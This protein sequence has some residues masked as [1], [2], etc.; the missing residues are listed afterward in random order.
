MTILLVDDEILICN[1]ISMLIDQLDRNNLTTVSMSNAEDALAY[2]ETH[3]V[4][5]ILTDITMP[6][7]SGLDLIEELS[8]THPNIKTA[9][10]SAYDDY[11]Y[12]REAFKLGALD[13]ILKSEIKTEDLESL[14]NKLYLFSE[15][16]SNTALRN[17]LSK[18][19]LSSQQQLKALLSKEISEDA[20][21]AETQLTPATQDIGIG[22]LFLDKSIQCNDDLL[23]IL[24]ILSRTL[25]SEALV[26]DVFFADADCF[27]CLFNISTTIVEYQ[28]NLMN[29]LMLLV[30]RN[31]DEYSSFSVLDYLYTATDSQTSLQEKLTDA[32]SLVDIR[33]YYPEASVR[34]IH[35]IPE[36]VTKK[37]NASLVRCLNIGKYDEAVDCLLDFKNAAHHSLWNPRQLRSA[38][39][40]AVTVLC[41]FQD[42]LPASTHRFGEYEQFVKLISQASSA[43]QLSEILRSFQT[44]YLSS[45]NNSQ[46]KITPAVRQAVDYINENYMGRL[47][48]EDIAAHVF[49]NKA[50]ISQIFAKQ[51]NMSI[52]SYIE[53]VRIQRAKTLLATTNLSIS[54]ISEESGYSSQS[55]F[56]KVFKKATGVGPS[57]YRTMLFADPFDIS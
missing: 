34:E 28:Q 54:Q 8:S 47:T 10:L 39:I 33:N 13:Y 22:L 23:S 51:M 7:K 16:D 53:K 56:T 35:P 14:L 41:S 42:L 2:C 17:S 45:V 3:P 49:L 37:L 27:V 21:L 36:D 11:K 9:V 20:F 50:Y 46:F 32:Y 24:E 1:W 52:G 12:I 57:S 6:Q 44:N 19:Q 43:E 25:Q 18:K 26:G 5:L 29:K 40:Y 31:I 4:D 15:W 30:Q 38:V 55:Y 48:L